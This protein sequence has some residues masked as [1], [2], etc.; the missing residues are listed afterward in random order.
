M[1]RGEFDF[2][3]RGQLGR[4]IPAWPEGRELVFEFSVTG[5]ELLGVEVKE[6]ER[7]LERKEMFGSPGAREGLDNLVF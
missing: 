2:G 7:L 3:Q 1:A 6:L 5:G 4:G